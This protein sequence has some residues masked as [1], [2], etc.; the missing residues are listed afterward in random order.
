MTKHTRPMFKHACRWAVAATLAALAPAAYGQSET[1]GVGITPIAAPTAGIVQSGVDND[2]KLTMA[3]NKTAVLTTKNKAIRVSTG[4][5]D[6]ADVTTVGTNTILVTAKKPGSTQVVVWDE[7]EQ[8]QAIDVSVTLDIASL[9]E[10]VKKAYPDA[11]ITI[12]VVNGQITLRGRVPSL[13]VADEVTKLATA[14]TKD[15]MNFL[16]VGGGQQIVLNV[17]FIEVSRAASN[18]L[19]FSAN[20]GGGSDEHRYDQRPDR[21]ADRRPPHWSGL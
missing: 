17:Q 18:Q 11:P 4:Q 14:Y 8:S 1:T 5:P 10:Q 2:G 9:R 13:K 15:V 6:V 7:K 20:F 12:D 16:E 21:L 19:G 3:V